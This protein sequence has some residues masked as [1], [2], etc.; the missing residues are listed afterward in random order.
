MDRFK[1]IDANIEDGYSFIMERNDWKSGCDKWLEAWEGIKE[2]FAEGVAEDIFDLNGKYKWTQPISNYA[3]DLEMELHNA[4]VDDSAYHQKR[5]VYCKELIQWCKDELTVNNTRIGMAE[6]YFELG[7]YAAGDQIF[8][9]WLRDDPESGM[10]HS[11]WANCYRGTFDARHYGK[12][13]E[14]L[15]AAYARDMLRDRHYV[16][17][18]L[19]NLYNDMGKPD[20][21]KEYADIYAKLRPATTAGIAAATKASPVRVVKIGRNEPCPC[22]SGK[23][24]KKCCG[25]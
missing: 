21:A 11:G 7:D 18:G 3:Q 10:G 6:A 2:L 25:A 23:K 13:E 4:G 1:R 9:E 5:V 8:N 22:G 20:K 16:V 24:Y 12:A 15:L 19:V 14:I 17:E